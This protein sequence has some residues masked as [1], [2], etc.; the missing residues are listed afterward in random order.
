FRGL[1]AYGFFS[2][3]LLRWVAPL[4]MMAL[5]VSNAFLLAQ[6]PLYYTAFALQVLLYF[7]A[8]IGYARNGRTRNSKLLLIPFYFVSM[9]LALVLGMLKALFKSEG[10]MWNRIERGGTRRDPVE[11]PVSARVQVNELSS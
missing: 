5:M 7:V 2:H 4:L 11:R 3:K 8:G 6:G 1:V 9:N 10:G